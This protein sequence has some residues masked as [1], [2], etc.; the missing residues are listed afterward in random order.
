[1]QINAA[2]YF[3]VADLRVQIFD[4]QHRIPSESFPIT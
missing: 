2:K 3:L 4:I 1:M